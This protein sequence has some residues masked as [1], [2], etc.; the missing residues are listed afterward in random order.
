LPF[1]AEAT[2]DFLAI[3]TGPDDLDGHLL[4]VGIL[5]QRPVDVAHAA[6]AP[7]LFDPIGTKA[8]A[9]QVV[10]GS[11]EG[12]GRKSSVGI[13]GGEQVLSVDETRLLKELVRPRRWV[14]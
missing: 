2:Q 1:G 6:A 3:E 9:E 4:P 10:H 12:E 14:L 11:D 13:V 5:P 8:F 7:P